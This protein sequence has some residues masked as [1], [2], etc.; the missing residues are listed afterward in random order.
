MLAWKIEKT[1]FETIYKRLASYLYT[2]AEAFDQDGKSPRKSAGQATFTTC[3]MMCQHYC[4]EMACDYADTNN[5]E[6]AVI[7]MKMQSPWADYQKAKENATQV[8]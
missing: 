3:D 5:L 2:Y 4:D 7:R 8:P 1:G 6:R